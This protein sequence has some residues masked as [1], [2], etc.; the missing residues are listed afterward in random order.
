MMVIFVFYICLTVIL[1]SELVFNVHDNF[2]TI[3]KMDQ[4]SYHSISI[5]L[6]LIE[7]F[8]QNG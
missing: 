1:S 5:L 2:V 7:K 3:R 4:A 6:D 8:D